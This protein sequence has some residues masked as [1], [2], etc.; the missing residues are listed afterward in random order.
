MAKVE[1]SVEIEVEAIV[2]NDATHT[3]QVRV[4]VDRRQIYMTLSKAREMLLSLADCIGKAEI[5]SA[6]LSSAKIG[7]PNESIC[8]MESIIEKRRRE[9]N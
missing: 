4:S 2:L 9:M 5:Y 8:T 1:N 6:M 3:P 7:N